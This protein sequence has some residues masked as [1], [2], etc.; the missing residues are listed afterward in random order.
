MVAARLFGHRG[1]G[2][3][4]RA[5]LGALVR[6]VVAG[7]GAWSITMLLLEVEG[8]DVHPF[9]HQTLIEGGLPVAGGVA[10]HLASRPA[11]SVVRRRS[12][13]SSVAAEAES[14]QGRSSTATPATR[15]P[16]S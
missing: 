6:A 2:R 5:D 3:K 11:R 1:E 4:G 10:A 15:R 14:S 12:A 16:A 13:Y 7:V 8:A 9:D